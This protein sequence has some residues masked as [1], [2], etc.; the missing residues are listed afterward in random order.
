M[1]RRSF[2]GLALAALGIPHLIRRRP[3]FPPL[4]YFGAKRPV[5]RNATI[6]IDAERGMPDGDGSQDRPFRDLSQLGRCQSCVILV[7][8]R[9]H[10]GQD[11]NLRPA[12]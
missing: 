3:T 11:S 10:G 9:Q 8:G 7:S 2:I 5:L 1:N 4:P 6:Y 12:V